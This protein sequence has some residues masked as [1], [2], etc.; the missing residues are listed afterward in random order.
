VNIFFQ[1][2]NIGYA[3]L[4]MFVFVTFCVYTLS[5]SSLVPY[6]ALPEVP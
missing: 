6:Q 3:V 5:F 1:S 2:S 4:A